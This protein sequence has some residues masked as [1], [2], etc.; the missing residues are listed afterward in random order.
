[1]LNA[2]PLLISFQSPSLSR[3]LINSPQDIGVG[4]STGYANEIKRNAAKIKNKIKKLK[5]V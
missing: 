3:Q 5:V 4:I 2:P 1:M